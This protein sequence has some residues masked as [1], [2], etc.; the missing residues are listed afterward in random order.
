MAMLLEVV[1]HLDAK[2]QF[3]RKVEVGLHQQNC[4]Q[5]TDESSSG[6]LL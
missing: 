5:L 2:H 3:L 4:H 6:H 1:H